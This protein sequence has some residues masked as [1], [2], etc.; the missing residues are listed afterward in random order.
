MDGHFTDKGQVYQ[1][2]MEEPV[3]QLEPEFAHY[4][5]DKL[6]GVS[7]DQRAHE[8]WVAISQIKDKSTSLVCKSQQ[9]S[10]S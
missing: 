3:D 1:P 4:Q 10:W 6:E 9:T 5:E 2:S 7:L 8:L